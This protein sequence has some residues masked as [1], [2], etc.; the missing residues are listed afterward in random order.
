MTNEEAER[1]GVFYDPYTVTDP[2]EAA[3]ILELIKTIKSKYSNRCKG[4]MSKLADDDWW[5]TQ[6]TKMKDGDINTLRISGTSETSVGGRR[7]F[8]EDVME[9]ACKGEKIPVLKLGDYAR[10]EEIADAE[11]AADATFEAI[12]NQK[13]T[14]EVIDKEVKNAIKGKLPGDDI[15]DL[16][17]RIAQ[18]VFDKI[19]ER[20]TK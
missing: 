5:V 2:A 3:L 7:K 17:E 12:F 13:I 19:I 6:L 8:I 20:L 9:V 15:D 4:K 14:S 18:A 10:L 11:E 1:L 16:V